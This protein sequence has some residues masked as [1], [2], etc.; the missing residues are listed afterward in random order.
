MLATLL[1]GSCFV[2]SSVRAA[3]SGPLLG[4]YPDFDF[5]RSADYWSNLASSIG[6]GNALIDLT[7]AEATNESIVILP[8]PFEPTGYLESSSQTDLVEPYLDRFESDGLKVILSIQ[9]LMSDV[10]EL[11]DI[12]LSRFGHH[13]N[14]LGVNVDL[15]W[16]QSGTPNYVSNRERDLWLNETK[17]KR[18]DLKLFLTYYK[19]YT[20]FPQD[21]TDLVVMFDGEGDTQ[22]NLLNKFEQIASHYN[23]VGIYTGYSSSVPPTASLERILSAVPNTQYIIHTSAV[24]SEMPTVVFEMDGVQVDYQEHTTINLLDLCLTKNMPLVCGVVPQ[25]LDNLSLG[26][27]YLPSYLRDLHQNYFDIFEMAQL[28]YTNNDSEI[29]A[30]KT[31]QEQKTVIEKGLQIMK[32][33]GISPTT[34]VPPSGS[35]DDTTLTVAEELG[36]K[37]FVDLYENLS[38]SKL[39]ILDSW[40]SLI[41]QIANGTK[42]K[43]PEQLMAEIDQK[44]PG[45]L[46]IIEYQIQDFVNNS[47]TKMTALSKIID[48][49]ISS[50]K[51]VFMTER[52][53][54]ETLGYNSTSNPDGTTPS[55]TIPE[56]EIFLALGTSVTI[57]VTILLARKTRGLKKLGFSRSR[58][59]KKSRARAAN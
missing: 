28:G 31:Y 26:G 11:I 10:T 49:L 43:S 35:A 57:A 56:W 16:K 9:P 5:S 46:T 44:A 30:G 18:S 42:L 3:Q 32:S 4:V 8:F 37:N 27:G 39:L 29:L 58:N 12:V 52:Q 23:S 19:D 51:Y 40:V 50:E 14:I 20:H 7:V 21:T 48:S 1:L 15:E 24:S 41:D 33:V 6:G 47:R 55:P 2:F 54:Q 17:G 22:T 38:S 59:R 25:G 36:F 45:D 53:Y 34:F 13:S